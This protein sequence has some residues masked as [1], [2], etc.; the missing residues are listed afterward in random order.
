MHLSD[1]T[2]ALQTTWDPPDTLDFHL[3]TDDAPL[4]PALLLDDDE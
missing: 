2:N 1:D 4:L 3:L